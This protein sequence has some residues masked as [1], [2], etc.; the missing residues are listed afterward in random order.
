MVAPVLA[1][2]DLVVD[3]TALSARNTASAASIS[4]FM[5]STDATVTLT[6]GTLSETVYSLKQLLNN[7]QKGDT[8]AT[9]ATGSQGPK[10]DTGNTGATGPQGPIGLTGATGPQGPQG[11]KGDTG[12]V[13]SV[14][15]SAIVDKPATFAPAPHVHDITDVTGL[16]NMLNGKAPV[17]NP[18]FG[19]T[20]LLPAQT[21][22]KRETAGSGEGGQFLLQKPDVGGFAA[23]TVVDVNGTSIRF[24]EGTGAFRG[25]YLQLGECASGVGSRIWTSSDFNPANYSATSH[26]H[27]SFPTRP[28]FN[29]A[30]PWDSANL[31]SPSVAAN[32]NTLAQ[33][34]GSG[35]L[36]A[37]LVNSSSGYKFGS[38]LYL[39]PD[40]NDA[41]IRTGG[42]GAEKYTTFS[43]NGWTYINN[44]GLVASEAIAGQRF[45]SNYI[46]V[47][48]RQK[49]N[50][51]AS[52]RAML[53][54]KDA[55]DYYMLL[56]D[57]NDADGGFNSFRPLRLS[58]ETGYIAIGHGLGVNGGLSVPSGGL[59]V[60]GN[61]SLNGN[62]T[63]GG[64]YL[65]IGNG[66]NND[67]NSILLRRGSMEL[68]E[69]NPYID[70]VR[71]GS[72]DWHGRIQS[73]A[74]GNLYFYGAGSIVMEAQ[75]G[76]AVFINGGSGRQA[77]EA[78]TQ[79]GSEQVVSK[80]IVFNSG[81]G[82]ATAGGGLA[83]LEVRGT[84]GDAPALLEFH[85][86]GS[87]GAYF[88]LRSDNEF[89][90]GGWSY[91][92]Q[93]WKVFTERNFDPAGKLNTS[94][95]DYSWTAN[96]IPRR[97][98]VGSLNVRSINTQAIAGEG[99]KLWN[100]STAFSVYMSDEGNSTFGGN[101]ANAPAAD[102]N[103]YFRMEGTG[104]GWAFHNGSVKAKI[105][106]NGEATFNGVVR[107][108]SWF[109]TSGNGLYDQNGG[110]GLRFAG[111]AGHPYGTVSVYANGSNGW[112]GINLRNDGALTWMC[113]A[114]NV[115]LHHSSN[116]WLING[117]MQGN[118]TFRGNVTA[119]SDLRLKTDAR[120]IPDATARR[121]NL[122]LAAI[123]YERDGRTRIGY[124][125][126]TVRLANPEFVHEAD[127]A[128]KIATGMG[129]LSVDYGE[130][131]AV[132]AVASKATD[133]RV[134]A[135]ETIIASLEARLANLESTGA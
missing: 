30:T 44:G 8:G 119:F 38:N 53:H 19:G 91:G 132:L 32:G 82:F 49:D 9:G 103:T 111:T 88:G 24:F 129:T 57:N 75:N 36:A 110:Q 83:C 105:D 85:R 102:Y 73:N 68:R 50:N 12:S 124:G 89:A 106:G 101:V 54:Y 96:T 22:F 5:F 56:T 100:G 126:Q 45:Q 17:A 11:I 39:Y 67:A 62:V 28:T 47:G 77:G 29:G 92:A 69:A 7:I 48:L 51:T 134:A 87:F 80:S 65:E 40:N 33:R 23:D 70:L 14:P 116:S 122:A 46:G 78:L 76:G 133:D 97:D 108:N 104:R 131:T 6:D 21:I 72:A 84:G 86:P 93:S 109:Y 4:R 20:V 130:T 98:G 10:G 107:T 41:V 66:S 123:M 127:D 16:L 120:A 135:L 43:N 15:W 118:F 94:E 52:G 37:S 115:G 117:D 64:S 59:S 1:L 42:A 55:N 74:N 13:S 31:N 95:V 79:S 90:V 114:D 128:M 35:A 112:Q 113:N 121:D 61:S 25:A 99:L 18:D 81:D 2:Q 26:S 63:V 58:L 27:T 60:T 3:L 34:D 125:A 71:D